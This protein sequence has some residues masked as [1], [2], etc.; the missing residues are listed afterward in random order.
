MRKI[1]KNL[2]VAAALASISSI[3]YA[4]C[5]L[6]NQKTGWT[7]S[8]TFH[9][10]KDTDLLQNPVTFKLNNNAKVN[11]VWGIDGKPTVTEQGGKAVIAIQKWYPEGQ[12]YILPANKSETLS[13]SASTNQYKVTDFS[14]GDNPSISYG[15]VSFKQGD[16]S[17]NIPDNATITLNKIGD[18]SKTYTFKWFDVKNGASQTVLSGDYT[19]TATTVDGSAIKVDPANINIKEGA[20]VNISLNYSGQV[21]KSSKAEF[22]LGDAP[23]GVTA[24]KIVAKIVSDSGA[25]QDVD[26]PWGKTTA[27]ELSSGHTYTFSADPISNED[28][29]Y[30]FIFSPKSVTTTQT[31]KEYNVN[32]ST[33]KTQ[34]YQTKFNVSN[35][36]DALSTKLIITSLDPNNTLTK[37]VSVS[38]GLSQ[39]IMLPVGQYSVDATTLSRGEYQYSL[40]QKQITVSS[41]GQNI[42]NIAFDKTKTEVKHVKGWPNYIAMG[43]VT[44]ANPTSISQLENRNVDAIFKYAGDGGNGDPGKIVFPVY[45]QNTIKLANELSKANN[46]EVRPVMV[47]YT[48]Q[49]SG[50][51]AYTDFDSVDVLAKHFINLMLVAQVLEGKNGLDT[52]TTGSIIMNP[53]LLGNI[54]QNRLYNPTTKEIGDM[55]EIYVNESLR[56]AYWFIHTPHNWTFHLQNGSVLTIHNETPYQ[57]VRDAYNG[58]FKSKGIYSP[59]DIKQAFE[60]ESESIL[61]NA[62]TNLQ[63]ANLPKFE[64]NFNG[65]VQATNWTI[66]KMAPDVTFGWQENV[67]NVNSA[68]WVHKYSNY[69]QIKSE[70]TDPTLNLWDDIGVYSG[71]YKPDF[72]VFDKYE[73]DALPAAAGIGYLWNQRDWKNYLMYVQQMSQGLDGVPVMLWQM[74]GGHLQITDSK[75]SGYSHGSTAPDFF[76]GDDRLKPNLSNVEEYIQNIVLPSSAYQC[77]DS[78]GAVQYLNKYNANWHT[79][80]LS[81]AAHSNVFAILWGGGQTTSVGTF[82]LAGGGSDWLAS[83]VNNYEKSI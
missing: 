80:H 79:N 82:P 9:C 42:F 46:H 45:T 15:K 13:F 34:T 48:G 19:V 3:S 21:Q 51:T 81:L 66:K 68:N 39:P 14:I 8:I 60:D 70:I 31:T 63:N 74:P 29:K 30:D 75:Y 10:D 28:A 59:W 56:E 62:P 26:L 67:W 76:F 44:N 25:V 41:S 27:V 35:L 33:E 53:D 77:G 65:W 2:I 50:G 83:K 5:T 7:G 49:M 73:M 58:K 78:C 71:E 55:K 18:D 6:D 64:N 40:Q 4:N 36:P 43:A 32:I 11:S 57:V 72:L 17:K 22:V 16:D 23:E 37:T 52:D 12:P 24:E 69:E 54:Q 38:N 1:K 47:V 20:T 61:Q